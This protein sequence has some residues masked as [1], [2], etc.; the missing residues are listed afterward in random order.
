MAPVG[1][2]GEA[3]DDGHAGAP[4]PEDADA[5]AAP[6]APTAPAPGAAPG[7][8]GAVGRVLLAAT[9]TI[10]W[11]ISLPFMWKSVTTVPSA[12]RLQ[13]MQSRIMHVPSPTTFLRLT[14]QSFLELVV[15]L[16]LLW[17]GWR[18]FWLLR[19]LLAFLGLALWAV[20]TVPLELTEL[21]RVHHAWL[22][23]SDAILL[24]AFVVSITAAVVGAV[25][26]A[27]RRAATSE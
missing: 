22:L 7:R 1:D 13:E 23:G 26:G 4:V 3:G 19:L 18:P 14:G 12:A 17:P 5:P 2:G 10:T 24:L 21:A 11:L 6:A 27:R 16:L 9:L 8:L 20:L 15:L 25:R